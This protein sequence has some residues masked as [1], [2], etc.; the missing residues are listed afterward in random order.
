M[1]DDS[2]IFKTVSKHSALSIRRHSNKL[3]LRSDSDALHSVIDLDH[4]EKLA[5]KNLEYLIA[6]LLFSPKPQRILLLGTGGGSLVQFLRHHYPDSHLTSVDIDAELLE[7]MHEKMQL[8]EASEHLTYVIDDAAHY[9]QYCD[10]QFDL[11]LVDIFIGDQSPDW[12]LDADSMQRLYRLLST[13]GSV[14][15]NL[16]ID[17]E[18]AFNQY[19]RNLRETFSQQTL[20]IPVEGY[21]NTIAYGFRQS[22][23]QQDMAWYMQRAL[24]LGETHDINYMEVLS[25]IYMTNPSGSG[26]I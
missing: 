23:E 11:I 20:C 21:D 19:Y 16:L 13:R 2:S 6:I 4:P 9:L 22:P 8:P 5:L 25:A 26:V 17:D 24:D 7:L 18:E 3:E 10:Q 1:T 12:L 15:Y 14:A